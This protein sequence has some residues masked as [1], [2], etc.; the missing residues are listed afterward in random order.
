MK[1]VVRYLEK[2]LKQRHINLGISANGLIHILRYDN[3]R[4]ICGAIDGVHECVITKGLLITKFIEYMMH[5]IEAVKTNFRPSF[6]WDSI[7]NMAA[8][9]MNVYSDGRSET[10]FA[11]LGESIY[12]S[13][14]YDV[15]V[16]HLSASHV[17]MIYHSRLC[18]KCLEIFWGALF[19][20]DEKYNLDDIIDQYM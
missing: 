14:E 10:I 12:N 18:R 6:F 17:Q 2:D 16:D 15:H 4:S 7:N 8:N 11:G 5:K 19:R 3:N 1:S 20:C 13:D 9:G